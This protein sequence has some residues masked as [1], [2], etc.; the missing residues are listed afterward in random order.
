MSRVCP[1]RGTAIG[2]TDNDAD[3]YLV[4][5]R[6]GKALYRDILECLVLL[7]EE[8]VALVFGAVSTTGK[9]NK[10]FTPPGAFVFHSHPGYDDLI[11]DVHALTTIPIHQEAIG[12][13]LAVI[14]TTLHDAE[15]L[16]RIRKRRASLS[17]Q[18]TN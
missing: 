10:G 12:N 8:S 18:S 15:P 4:L 1:S 2:H 13:F 11:I 17:V 5:P 14:E 3:R 7:E 6:L 9:V 16:K